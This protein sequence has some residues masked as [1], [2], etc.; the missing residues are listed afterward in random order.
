MSKRLN[1]I[2][3]VSAYLHWKSLCLF[4]CLRIVE[5]WYKW[6]WKSKNEPAWAPWTLLVAEIR[7]KVVWLIWLTT[8]HQYLTRR[9]ETWMVRGIPN[10][11][12]RWAMS[13]SLS[14]SDSETQVSSH[15]L[16]SCFNYRTPMIS[17]A[18]FGVSLIWRHSAQNFI[19]NWP[20]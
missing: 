8:S 10:D 2:I 6:V 18:S 9:T 4:G 16:L 14:I 20:L 7:C 1:H 15:Q 17:D 13:M 12:W 5:F 3:S 19:L 11:T